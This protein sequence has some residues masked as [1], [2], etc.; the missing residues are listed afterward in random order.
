MDS[1][2]IEGSFFDPQTIAKIFNIHI[3][4]KKEKIKYVGTSIHPKNIKKE[5]VEHPAQMDI[6][7]FGIKPMFNNKVSVVSF[8]L[9]YIQQFF[10]YSFKVKAGIEQLW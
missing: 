1:F 9:V 8:T 2:Q 10:F 4:L 5:Y 7:L 6:F 3:Q